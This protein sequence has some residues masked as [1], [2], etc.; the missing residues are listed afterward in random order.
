[1]PSSRDEAMSILMNW[2]AGKVPV[3]FEMD[4]SF[5]M[6]A[7]GTAKILPESSRSELVFGAEG[8]GIRFSLLLTEDIESACSRDPSGAL[9]VLLKL[10]GEFGLHFRETI[11]LVSTG[12]APV[13]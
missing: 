12:H 3:F 2:K 1:M 7:R 9:T 5:K 10:V 13:Q 6:V 8:A 4:L 11:P